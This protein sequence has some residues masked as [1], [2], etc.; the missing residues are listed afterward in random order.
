MANA[1]HALARV[2]GG[3]NSGGK[4]WWGWGDRR[5]NVWSLQLNRT[6][7]LRLKVSTGVGTSTINLESLHVTSLD[8]NVGRTM[9]TLPEHGQLLAQIDGG[10]GE[11]EVTI[12]ASMAAKIRVR[13]GLGNMQIGSRYQRQGDY[14]LSPNY[15]TA[16]NRVELTVNG[17]IGSITIR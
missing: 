16:T 6:A 17:G 1:L 8:V 2:I 12:P 14:Y 13:A 9:V 5:D 15:D 7:P 10:V 4:P 3:Q 11:T